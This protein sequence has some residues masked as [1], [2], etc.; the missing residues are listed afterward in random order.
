[1]KSDAKAS[2]ADCLPQADPYPVPRQ[3]PHWKTAILLIVKHDTHLGDDGV[4]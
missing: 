2:N 3:Q 1:M 4:N